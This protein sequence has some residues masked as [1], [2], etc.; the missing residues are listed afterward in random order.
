MLKSVAI[1]VTV[2]VAVVVVVLV[3]IVL[4]EFHVLSAVDGVD[5]GPNMCQR[6]GFCVHLI[7]G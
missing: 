2:R 5:A 3:K 6:D 7:P 1:D 4:I